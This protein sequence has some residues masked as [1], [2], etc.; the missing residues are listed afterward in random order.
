MVEQEL[1]DGTKRFV[2]AF[3]R[4]DAAA[5]ADFYTDD[6]KIL[7]PN[8]EMVNGKQAIKAFWESAKAMGVRSMNLET[9]E[10]G[11]DGDLAYERGI[12]TVTIQP[13]GAQAS[14]RRGKYIVILKRQ[15]DGEWKLAVDI[16]NTDLP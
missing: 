6:A 5:C 4:G 7:P 3:N 8:M 14:T 2:E 15:T 12:S 1:K 16:W 13:E 9:V 11:I 10:V